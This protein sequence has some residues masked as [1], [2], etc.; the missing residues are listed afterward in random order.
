MNS[1]LRLKVEELFFAFSMNL[2]KENDFI[3]FNQLR[4]RYYSYLQKIECFFEK[5][6]H[7]NFG[8]YAK[9]ILHNNEALFKELFEKYIKDNKSDKLLQRLENE[10]LFICKIIR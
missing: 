2:A 7:Q 1:D 4:K 3:Q 8:A 9:E 5:N 6:I 10:Y